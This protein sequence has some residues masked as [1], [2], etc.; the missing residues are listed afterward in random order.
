MERGFRLRR[1]EADRWRCGRGW[2]RGNR[3]RCLGRRLRSSFLDGREV[4]SGH[5]GAGRR[6]LYAGL[7]D[8]TLSL[9]FRLLEPPV[10]NGAPSR[11]FQR[12]RNAM[13]REDFPFCDQAQDFRCLIGSRSHPVEIEEPLLRH[14]ISVTDG[15]DRAK[16][17]PGVQSLPGFSSLLML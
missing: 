6:D 5:F 9:V 16:K 2:R 7:A 13:M 17:N 14:G 10:E 12:L 1:L 15:N 8:F 4:E 3:S 11:V